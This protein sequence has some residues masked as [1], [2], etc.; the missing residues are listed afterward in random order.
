MLSLLRDP[1]HAYRF[2]G[3]EFVAVLTETDEAGALIVAERLREEVESLRFPDE[4][5]PAPQVTVSVGVAQALDEDEDGV[6][7]RADH[8]LYEAKRLGRNCVRV[9]K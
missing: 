7:A 8:A 4:A 2:G 5:R 6:L 3:E 9:A 1:D